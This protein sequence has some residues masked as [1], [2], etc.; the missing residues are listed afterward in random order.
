MPGEV[1]T[2]RNLPHWYVPCAVHFVTYRLAGTIPLP[3]L[4]ALRKERAERLRQEPRDPDP[5]ATRHWRRRVHG[6][7]FADYDRY[8]D[9]HRDITWL[10]DPRIAA[11][12]R[13]NLHHLD[14][15]IYHLLAYCIMPNHVH[16]L[17]QPTAD[18][19]PADDAPSPDDEEP[20]PSGPLAAIMR[21]LK[22]YTAREANRLLGRSGQFWQRES[23]DHWVRDDDELLRLVEYVIWNPV[24]AGL[25]AEPHAWYWSSAHHR[26]LA[27]GSTSGI[28][29]PPVDPR[30]E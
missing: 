21:R 18:L 10:A 27:D 28:L 2:R 9:S 6:R 23:Y 25:A 24:N 11:L 12:V 5:A 30:S 19:A 3:V 14:G 1:I 29:R 22:S 20:A 26:F 7:F 13:G 4:D 15:G 16:V 17:H 8:L